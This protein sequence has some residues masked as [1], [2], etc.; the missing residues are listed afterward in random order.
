MCTQQRLRQAASGEL[1]IE[2]GQLL[3]AVGEAQVRGHF[4]GTLTEVST[5]ALDCVDHSPQTLIYWNLTK[6]LVR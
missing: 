4:S 6:S 5:M 2:R 3:A 1:R